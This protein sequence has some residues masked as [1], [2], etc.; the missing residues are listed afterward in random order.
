MSLFKEN[1]CLKSLNTF[2]I[3][4]QTKYFAEF[5]SMNELICILNSNIYKNNDSFILGGGSNILFTK[6]Y[7]GVVIH[8]RIQGIKLLNNSNFCV[9]KSRSRRKL[10]NFC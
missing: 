4:I 10:A 6:N 1:Y 7:E 5:Y 3:K 8:N 9:C 2:K